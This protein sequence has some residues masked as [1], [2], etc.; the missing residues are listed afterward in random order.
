MFCFCF[1]FVQLHSAPVLSLREEPGSVS[2]IQVF[3]F[4]FTSSYP[5]KSIPILRAFWLTMARNLRE[6]PL[7]SG[8]GTWAKAGTWGGMC[9]KDTFLIIKDNSKGKQ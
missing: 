7:F 2:E 3:V 9:P 8:G 6:N 1:L 5:K 4:C